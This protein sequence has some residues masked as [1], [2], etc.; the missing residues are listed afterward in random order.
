[1][2]TFGFIPYLLLSYLIALA[3]FATKKVASVLQT[4]FVV[5]LL[6]FLG[7]RQR[8]VML[9]DLTPPEVIAQL[10]KI[11][12]RCAISLHHG[13]SYIHVFMSDELPSLS[14]VDL[15][16]LAS[17]RRNP[18]RGDSKFSILSDDIETRYLRCWSDQKNPGNI[19]DRL[20]FDI[21][22][23]PAEEARLGGVINQLI[24]EGKTYFIFSAAGDDPRGNFMRIARDVL[25][26]NHPCQRVLSFRQTFS[27]QDK[28]YT[29]LKIK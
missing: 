5:A 2:L 16:S 13:I 18:G 4:A 6:I 23:S 11:P 29:I 14:S 15:I 26:K 19:D 12:P 28:E 22:H 17:P 8:F 27:G 21:Q 9:G 20:I 10:Q 25:I 24:T 3:T 1:L 7:T